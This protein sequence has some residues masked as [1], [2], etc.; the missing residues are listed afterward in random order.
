M[1]AW[2]LLIPAFGLALIILLA[3]QVRDGRLHLWV[4]NVGQGD[5]IMLRTPR[6]HT[7]LVVGGQGAT[8]LLNG[9]GNN[10]PFWQRDLDLL[11]LNHPTRTI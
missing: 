6:G 9:V 5:A 3:K 11:V 7:A 4:F 2:T 8:S 1:P 10:V